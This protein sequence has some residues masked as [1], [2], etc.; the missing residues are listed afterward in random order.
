MSFI[1]SILAGLCLVGAFAAITQPLLSALLLI[2]GQGWIVIAY[3]SGIA[4]SQRK[5]QLLTQSRNKTTV[6]R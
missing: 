2:A 4:A 5:A 6:R 1:Y 3:L